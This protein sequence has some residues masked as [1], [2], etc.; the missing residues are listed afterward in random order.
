LAGL[1]VTGLPALIGAASSVNPRGS[2]AAGLGVLVLLVVLTR[3]PLLVPLS[4]FQNV[5]IARLA[6]LDP[7]AR[8]RLLA[9]AAGLIIAGSLL[10][11][12]IAA[13]VGPPLLP[14]V[15]GD[16][17]VAS[18][19]LIGALVAAAAGLGFIA[20][21][22]A[23]AVAEGRNGAYLLGWGLAIVFSVAAM[24]LL[25]LPIE[26][27]TVAAVAGGPMLGAVVHLVALTKQQTHRAPAETG[28]D[29]AVGVRE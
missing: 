18:G 15:F 27:A 6:G 5:L 20:V 25:P 2:T 19:W 7:K 21:T 10:G 26:W 13:L 22:G 17:Y 8:G 28:R 11:G 12:V 1:L 29:L 9:T 16:Q 23:A 4:S 24:F 3:A 14:L